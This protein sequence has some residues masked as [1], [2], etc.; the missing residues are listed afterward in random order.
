MYARVSRYE[1]PTDMIDDDIRGADDTQ[2]Q[3]ADMPGSHGLYY[4]VDRETGHTMSITLWDDEHAMLE[5]EN[6]ANDLRKQTS[7][8]SSAK[9]M[10]IERYEVVTQPAELPL[11]MHE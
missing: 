4:L 9:I 11:A 5:S 10:S 1:V 2:R 7:S 6:A 8:A 3:V